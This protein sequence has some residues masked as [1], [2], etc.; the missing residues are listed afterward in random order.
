MKRIVAIVVTYNRKDMLLNCIENILKQSSGSPDVL[1]IDNASTDGTGELIKS[2]YCDSVRVIY[3]NTGHNL[4]GAGGFSYGLNLAANMG[5]DYYWIMDDD[6][7]PEDSALEGLL[8]A[9][10][11]LNDEFGFL[12]SY[13]KWVDG[14]PCVMN[15]PAVKTDWYKSGVS[16]QFD[17][18]LLMITSAS[19]VSMFI[20][21]DVVKEMGLPIKE[22][23]IWADDVEYSL[24]ISS[25]Y[26][27]FFVYESQVIHAIKTN[28][29]A[30][31]LEEPDKER[32]KRFTYLYR[33]K[34]YIAR[35]TSWR[36]WVSYWLE[37]NY[38]SFKII[39]SGTTMKFRRLGA[40]YKG[41]L[42]G[43]F[44]YPRIEKVHK[45]E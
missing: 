3:Q 22:F 37:F 10:T 13:A 14:S 6:T 34:Y 28:T 35:R 32:L 43:L 26:D 42:K 38:T 27:S 29:A 18:R 19:F 9:A 36:A 44:F 2:Q 30:S 7:F 12:S 39:F 17:N 16:K 8:S 33:N 40:M 31:L 20:K 25:R 4:G 15:L 45:C 1:V 5:Y 24:R 23:F 21:A 41:V 11:A